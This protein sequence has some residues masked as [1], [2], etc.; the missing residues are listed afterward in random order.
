[1]PAL[2]DSATRP[3]PNT[4]LPAAI[5]QRTGSLSISAPATG[6]RN[7]PRKVDRVRLYIT[8]STLTP[9][10]SRTGSTSRLTA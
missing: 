5:S 6:E 2:R 4:R 1:M 8:C 7:S 3:T 9:N 10:S